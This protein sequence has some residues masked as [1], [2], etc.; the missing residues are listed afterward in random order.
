MEK[1]HI[2]LPDNTG[3]EKGES[4]SGK[5]GS[6]NQLLNRLTMYFAER[7]FDKTLKKGD[8]IEKT[9]EFYGKYHKA[10]LM[11]L[12]LYSLLQE[13]RPLPPLDYAPL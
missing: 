8:K 7:I 1:I 5:R 9:Y 2:L 10:Y 11:T 3:R 12:H 4:N 6:I 13:K